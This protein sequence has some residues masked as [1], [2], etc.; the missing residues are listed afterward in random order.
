M[1]G[2]PRKYCTDSAKKKG[3]WNGSADDPFHAQDL[4]LE[5]WNPR[6]LQLRAHVS[7]QFRKDLTLFCLNK[8]VLN[9]LRYFVHC[10]IIA[11]CTFNMLILCSAY[12]IH[13]VVM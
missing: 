5:V 10:L 8:L 1:C 12:T 9:C 4:P 2:R 13:C 11:M 6:S 3:E 7:G